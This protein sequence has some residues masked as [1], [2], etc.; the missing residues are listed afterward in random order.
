MALTTQ[1]RLNRIEIGLIAAYNT[2]GYMT[3]I[4]DQAGDPI[5][6]DLWKVFAGIDHQLELKDRSLKIT[7]DL[8][9]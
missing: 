6:I 2:D 9:L 7:V 3:S 4:Y 5:D 1:D 8:K